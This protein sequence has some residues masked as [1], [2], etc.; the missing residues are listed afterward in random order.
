MMVKQHSALSN[1][2]LVIKHS[3][4]TFNQVGHRKRLDQELKRRLE[5]L[6]YRR[7]RLE[8]EL[9][10]VNNALSDIGSQMEAYKDYEQLSLYQKEQKFRI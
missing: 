8:N 1:E 10:A 5:E 4:D 7:T 9:N 2:N 6:Q 3:F